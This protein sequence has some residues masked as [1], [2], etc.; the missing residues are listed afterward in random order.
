MCI[1][2]KK[3]AAQEAPKEIIKKPVNYGVLFGSL[4]VFVGFLGASVTFPFLQAQRDQLGCDA[5]CY[6]T[7]QVR[8][9]IL[10]ARVPSLISRAMFSSSQ[11]ARSGLSMVG[12]VIVGRMSDKIGR[13]RV[14]FIGLTAS[15]ISYFIN[16]K[17]DSIIL[18]W[19]SMIPSSLL[20]QNFNVLKALFADYNVENGGTE[21]DR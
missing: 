2:D 7:M 9:S 15:V 19:L 3:I 12:S 5:L 8:S 21:S 16:L 11:S 13:S 20:N 17:G 18:M 4:S 6:G 10:K 1:P 14:L